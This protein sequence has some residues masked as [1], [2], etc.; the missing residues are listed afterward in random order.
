MGLRVDA[1]VTA[2]FERFVVDRSG[3]A[4]KAGQASE[5]SRS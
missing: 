5:R 4:R 1:G 2:V 3:E